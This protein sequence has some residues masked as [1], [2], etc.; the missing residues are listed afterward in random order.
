MWT[1]FCNVCIDFLNSQIRKEII[2]ELNGKPSSVM[3]FS[4]DFSFQNLVFWIYLNF[5]HQK[6]LKNQHLSHSESKT[7]QINSI[8]S[9]YHDLSNNTKGIFQ[10]L[11]HF[12]LQFNLIFSEEIIQCSRTFALQVQMSGNQAHAPLLVKSFPKD[13]ENMIWS[14]PVWCISYLQNKTNYLPS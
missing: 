7:Y 10:F 1:L 5:Q 9:T 14:I 11:L 2:L 3:M 4:A 6:S 12:Q 8:K 13:T